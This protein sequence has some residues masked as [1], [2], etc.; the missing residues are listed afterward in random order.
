M[1]QIISSDLLRVLVNR[2]RPETGHWLHPD[3]VLV[4]SAPRRLHHGEPA[5]AFP[6]RGRHHQTAALQ[7]THIRPLLPPHVQRVAEGIHF[8]AHAILVE[9]DPQHRDHC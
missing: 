9:E 4:P 5:A 6:T 3:R 2:S 1:P 7:I 8:E